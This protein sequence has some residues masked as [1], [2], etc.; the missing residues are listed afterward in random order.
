MYAVV[1]QDHRERQGVGQAVAPE[2]LQGFLSRHQFRGGSLQVAQRPPTRPG[3]HRTGIVL[4]SCQ[5]GDDRAR[6]IVIRDTYLPRPRSC[7]SR[8]WE[9]GRSAG[10]E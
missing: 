3:P 1:A 10:A 5:G 8:A 2:V 9:H 6:D 4:V 7:R